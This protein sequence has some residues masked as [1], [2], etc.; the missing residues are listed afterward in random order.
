MNTVSDFSIQYTQRVES[1]SSVALQNQQGFFLPFGVYVAPVGL[2]S[3]S[4]DGFMIASGADYVPMLRQVGSG[5]WPQPSTADVVRGAW[6]NMPLAGGG[7]EVIELRFVDR[8]LLIA[9]P[10]PYVTYAPGGVIPVLPPTTKLNFTYTSP[11]VPLSL[12]AG[13]RKGLQL[14]VWRRTKKS[15]S[16]RV[17]AAGYTTLRAGRHWSPWWRSAVAA[18]DGTVVIDP[19]TEGW[20]PSSGQRRKTY[21]LA[22]YDPES[23]ARSSL[24]DSTVF[25][26]IN[27]PDVVGT[28]VSHPIPSLWVGR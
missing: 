14:E 24:S 22:Y 17:N 3:M 13:A 15:G 8:K 2:L 7:G 23:G 12:F 1:I 27:R 4:V 28:S 19:T 16:V 11:Q 25:I 26:A 6:L 9:P 21:K 20:L 10:Q 5:G 18:E